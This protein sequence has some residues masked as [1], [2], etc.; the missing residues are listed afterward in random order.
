MPFSPRALLERG[1]DWL[2][3]SLTLWLLV[4][5]LALPTWWKHRALRHPALDAAPNITQTGAHIPGDPINFSVIGPQSSV[6]EAMQ[7]A[8][9]FPA[10]AIT[11][12]SSWRIAESTIFHRSYDDAPVSNLF[13]YGR[14]EDLAFEKPVGKDPRE[15]HHIR[16]WLAPERD[17]DGRPCWLGAVTF[18]RSVGFSHTTGQITHHI[19]PDLDAE[20]D[21][22]ISDLQTAGKVTTLDWRDG[23]L[24]QH[25]GRNGGGDPWKTDGRLPVLVLSATRSE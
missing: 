18:D 14:R 22:L 23:F 11:W 16:F 20:R 6:V 4:A 19:A 3:V 2:L 13:L 1:G 17:S 24:S 25:E 21:A 8:G 5:Y 9:W 12:R 15:R 10:D 7:S